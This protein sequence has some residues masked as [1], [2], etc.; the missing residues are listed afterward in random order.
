MTRFNFLGMKHIFIAF[1]TNDIISAK[2]AR[3][4][5]ESLSD[6]GIRKH[7]DSKFQMNGAIWLSDYNF[8]EFTSMKSRNYNALVMM[9]AMDVKY[10]CDVCHRGLKI[11]SEVGSQY[12]TQYSLQS[13]NLKERLAFFVM[14]VDSSR[15]LFQQMKIEFL[16]RIF[17]FP[18]DKINGPRLDVIEI[19]QEQ[20]LV[21]TKALITGL[22][23]I[24]GLEVS[25]AFLMTSSLTFI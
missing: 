15:K 6:S 13:K 2:I 8:S 21:N 1:L 7:L 20:A 24:L 23:E 9:T 4:G 18:V 17:M 14:D 12:A 16:P 25:A 22:N 19:N 11:F 3:H 5:S 10:G